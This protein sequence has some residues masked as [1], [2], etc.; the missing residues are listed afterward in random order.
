MQQNQHVRVTSAD[1]SKNWLEQNK[2]LQW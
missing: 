1:S 2:E